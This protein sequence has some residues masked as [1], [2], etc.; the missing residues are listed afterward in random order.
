MRSYMGRTGGADIDDGGA[1]DAHFGFADYNDTATASTPVALVAD[2]WTTLP[3]DG[4]GPF[5]QEQLPNGM[6]TMLGAGGAIDLT[7]LTQFSDVFVRP[8]YTVTPSS[9][10]ASL[11]FRFSLG[12]GADAYTLPTSLGRLD[13]GAGV[14]YRHSL[15]ALYIYAG[16]S[17]TI[18]NPVQL[19]IR[20]SA[21]GTVVNSGMAIKVFKK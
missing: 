3:N 18:D 10:N 19:Q 20:L 14:S 16:D 1:L 6:T 15:V 12:S 17:N 11:D 7:G 9:N 4:L 8:D 2:T 21:A 13:R 5:T